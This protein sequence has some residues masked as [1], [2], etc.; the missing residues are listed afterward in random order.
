MTGSID[1]ADSL[2]PIARTFE[3]QVLW[4][5]R[6]MLETEVAVKEPFH[7]T[8]A[9][10]DGPT[11]FCLIPTSNLQYH[12][13]LA[14]G[15]AKED[16]QGLFPAEVDPKFMLDSLGEMAN[17][18]AGLLMA[19]EDFMARFGHL[20]PSTP[21]FSEGAFTDRTDTGIRGSVT[22]NGT[23][24]VFHVIVR[25]AARESWHGEERKVAE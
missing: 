5:V 18:V 16:L 2:R 4:A 23:D 10:P 19:E 20:K 17:V 15:L 21:F 1:F 13:Q 11:L 12:A 3:R 14:V 25:D 24:M 7:V 8:N 6:A 22:V 9:A